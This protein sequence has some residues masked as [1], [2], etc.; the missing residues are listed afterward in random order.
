M[1]K[2]QA[3]HL[4]FGYLLPMLLIAQLMLL[5]STG[6]DEAGTML[7]AEAKGRYGG[8]RY[9]TTYRYTKYYRRYSGGSYHGRSTV[10]FW[11]GGGGGGGIGGLVC[12]CIICCC[13]GFFVFAAFTG[14]FKVEGSGSHHS[15]EEHHV[16]EVIEHHSDRSHEG[17]EAL[18]SS[19]KVIVCDQGGKPEAA[20]YKTP[21]L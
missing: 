19:R 15:Y 18:G 9:Y 4:I 13:L 3:H 11:G 7:L 2:K 12:C 21:L 5:W 16:V 10:V 14:R 20:S 8:G 17:G 6:D 1:L